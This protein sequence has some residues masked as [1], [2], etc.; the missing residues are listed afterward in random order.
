MK[1]THPAAMLA[2]AALAIL[3]AVPPVWAEA[4]TQQGDPPSSA[5]LADP[6]DEI[7]W[8]IVPADAA[9]VPDHRVSFRLRVDPGAVVTE[10][11]LVTNYSATPLTFDI[12][13]SDG[14]ISSDGSFDILRSDE[15]PVDVGSWIDV[16]PTVEVAAGASAL[17]PFT[18]TVPGN[19]TPGDHPGGIVA[20]L[21][22]TGD[23]VGGPQV[24][25]TTRVGVRIH[26]RVTGEIQPAL[27]YEDV[28]ASYEPSFNPF[29][30]G[31]LH[32]SYRVTNAG[33]VRIGS[34]QQAAVGGLFGMPT[35]AEGPSGTVVGQQ[36]EILPGQ[37]STVST[38]LDNTWPLGPITTTLRATREAVGDDPSLGLLPQVTAEV[39]VWAIPWAQIGVLLLA[40]ALIVVLVL[41]LRRRRLRFQHAIAR[42]RAEGARTATG[43]GLSAD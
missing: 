39:T 26:L 13:A 25:L 19:A 14:V 1:T 36:R 22:Q 18:V 30:P 37:S 11:A 23:A 32:V 20:G 7:S 28:K 29:A 9:G 4:P 40:G 27:S 31:R 12:L 33:N 15:K 34:I 3:L 24:G 5:S 21:T 42:A 2:A 38:V 17:V 41:I 10:H 8:G 43:A 16:Q 6:A 35:G